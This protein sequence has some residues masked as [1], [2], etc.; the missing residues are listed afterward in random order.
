MNKMKRNSASL[1][2][3]LILSAACAGGELV[4][5]IATTQP[6][7]R[8]NIILLM[9]DDLGWGDTGYNGN[10]NLRTPSLDE[11]AKSGLVFNRFYSAAPVCSPTRASV[12]TGRHP[13]RSQVFF[14]M[15]GDSQNG[16]PLGE[17]TLGHAMKEAGYRTGFFGKWHLGTMTKDIVD[18][19][20]GGPGAD[21]L[22]SPPW[23][24]GFDR[25]FATESR[26]PT[27]D[28]MVRPRSQLGAEPSRHPIEEPEEGSKRGWWGP[29]EN[30]DE[31]TFWGTHYWD[32]QEIVTDELSGDDSG[33]LIDEVI[34]FV[35]A[36]K[37]GEQP[38]FTV[39]WFHT[40]HL[41]LVA[42]LKDQQAYEEHDF[43]TR[44]YYGA[45]SAM[46]REIGRLR[47]ALKDA[48]VAD[49][50]V[51]WFMSDNG[52]ES[53]LDITPG[54]T[55]GLR[56]RKRSLHEGGI[57]VPGIIEWPARIEPG[58][59]TDIP[60]VTSDILPTV[61]EWA[62][63]ELPTERLLDGK[64]LNGILFG[65]ESSRNFPIGFESAYQMAWIDD[66]YKLVYAPVLDHAT[67]RKGFAGQNP[68]A[69]VDFELFDI[70]QD[71]SE[72]TDLADE[73][74]GIVSRM[75]DE[76]LRWRESVRYSINLDE[77]Q[78]IHALSAPAKHS[79]GDRQQRWLFLGDSITQAGHY[80]D[81]IET[82]LLLN[83]ANPPDI[84]DLGVSSETVS[85]DSEPDH[86]FP[87]PD[88]RSRLDQVLART[89]PDLVVACYGMNDAIYHPFS[90]DRFEAYQDGIRKLIEGAKT[91]GAEVILLTPPP[92]AGRINPR[93]GPQEGEAYSFRKPY[94]NY[95]AVLQRY[96]DWILSLDGEDG[97]RAFDIRVNLETYMADSYPT[98]PVHPS[99]YGH[100]IMAETFLENIGV[101]SG[102]DLLKTG[103][104]GKATDAQW[105]RLLELVRRQR[106]T[107]DRALLNNI[108]HGNPNVMKAFT[109]TLS[110]AVE[111]L[112][113]I[114]AD[115]ENAL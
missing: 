113:L 86:P 69:S 8:P 50:T 29:L 70:V 75:T 54:E 97:V 15:V 44:T 68:A 95:N 74:P 110:E 67:R 64:N 102:S 39:V 79:D 105:N 109:K 56:G 36:E 84:I 82:A 4:E 13:F 14:A 26:V 59:T 60:A 52:P 72:S 88:L 92:Y 12:L 30:P 11:M 89:R 23:E 40:P 108:G 73:Y 99:L 24:H 3:F 28:P 33:I 115:I 91:A 41:P 100:K 7:K 104:D 19:R 96:A 49:N 43:F 18:G 71:P 87:R 1:V 111:E 46:D 93:S 80:V 81:Y 25:V 65:D 6:Q 20:F 10:Q 53:L 27:Y 101:A 51:L 63:A 16:L 37:D 76:L 103:V 2:C 62:G 34:E 42:G 55:G 48:G 32:N 5:P 107:Y 114:N 77:S 17:P 66:Q 90:E 61:L 38:F 9:A 83:K 94:P 31:G 112:P 47:T 98:E 57:R 45:V 58:T 21:H 22:Y 35:S 85:R 106:E 78:A